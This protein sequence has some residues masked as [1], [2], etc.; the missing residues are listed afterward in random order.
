M[1]TVP[2]I[3]HPPSRMG[4]SHPPTQGPVFQG[5]SAVGMQVWQAKVGGEFQAGGSVG[6]Q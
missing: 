1:G 3:S 6:G 2:I 5:G 4:T